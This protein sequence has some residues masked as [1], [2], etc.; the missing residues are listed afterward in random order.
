MS[1]VLDIEIINAVEKH[2]SP[3]ALN[4]GFPVVWPNVD[5]P[6]LGEAYIHVDVFPTEA[7]VI[8]LSGGARHNWILQLRFYV[9]DGVGS[10]APLR[11]AKSFIDTLSVNFKLLGATTGK[12][13]K[14]VS[15]GKPLPAVTLDGW[16]FV[17]V[18]F[19]LH[20]IK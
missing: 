20:V 4:E 19:R 14:V 11:M 13:F 15:P 8:T 6:E 1:E 3:I 12:Q 10:L 16:Y 9:R 5:P 17:P 18:H 7:N 2:V